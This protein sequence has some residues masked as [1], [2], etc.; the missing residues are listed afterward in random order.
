[1]EADIQMPSGPTQLV[2]DGVAS[3]CPTDLHREA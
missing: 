2:T 1:M 3:M